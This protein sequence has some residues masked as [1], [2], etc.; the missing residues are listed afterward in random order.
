LESLQVWCVYIW[1]H[2]KSG[3]SVVGITTSLVCLSLGSLQVWCVCSWDHYKS[4]VSI[5]GITTSLVC[6]SLGSLQVW[7]VCSWDHYKSD[8]Q[9]VQTC[10]DPNDRHTRLV[11]IPTIYTP[12]FK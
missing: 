11:V 4:G 1:D 8:V 9:T 3:V 7:C 5:V 12:D 2:Y 10:N 6:L